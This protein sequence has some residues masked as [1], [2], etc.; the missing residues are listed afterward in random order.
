MDN[1]P[2]SQRAPWFN[3][4]LSSIAPG[5]LADL[6]FVLCERLQRPTFLGKSLSPVF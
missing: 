3:L 1:Q 6:K 5:I 4:D 2:G